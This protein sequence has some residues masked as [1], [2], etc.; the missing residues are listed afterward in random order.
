MACFK[1]IFVHLTVRICT[2]IIVWSVYGPGDRKIILVKMYFF[3]F[4]TQT[5]SQFSPRTPYF[6]DTFIKVQSYFFPAYTQFTHSD[7][8]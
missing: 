2:Y 5:N 1:I 3:K 8:V 6:I 4:Y 7:S